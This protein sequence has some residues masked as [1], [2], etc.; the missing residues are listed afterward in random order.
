MAQILAFKPNDF[1][2]KIEVSN[3]ITFFAAKP[4]GFAGRRWSKAL[5]ERETVVI[6][7]GEACNV[8]VP[9]IKSSHA[10]PG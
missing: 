7:A 2:P 5:E 1:K 4:R 6:A 3:L 9:R 8:A 10:S